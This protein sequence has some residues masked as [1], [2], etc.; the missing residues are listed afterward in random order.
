[1]FLIPASSLQ[2][3]WTLT[4]QSGTWE[5]PL[6]GAS[7]LYRILSPTDWTSSPP[8]YIIIWRPLFFLRASQFRTQFN[9]STVKVISW[10]LRPD[11]PVIYTG[12]F[13]ILT[14]WPGSICYN[15]AIKDIYMKPSASSRHMSLR[16]MPARR[17]FDFAA[18]SLYAILTTSS[19]RFLQ[20]Y[21]G[22]YGR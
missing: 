5:P 7:F 14:A 2:L 10:Y 8:S 12:V 19:S 15:R 20:N 1:M 13:P 17:R 18:H 3:I 22:R 11:A 6:L 4:A 16:V 9:P 21:F